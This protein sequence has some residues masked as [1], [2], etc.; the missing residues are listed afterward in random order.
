MLVNIPNFRAAV[1]VRNDFII[2]R[3][4]HQHHQQSL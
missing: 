1:S 2:F 3:T 4:H